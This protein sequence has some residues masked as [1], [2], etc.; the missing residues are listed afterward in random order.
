[1]GIY[2]K[3]E[4]Y[5]IDYYVNGRRRREKVGPSRALA[6][7]ALAV[8]KGEI[9]REKYQ[10]PR[11]KVSMFFE[12][13][14]PIYLEYVKGYKKSYRRDETSIHSLS[15]KFA[16]RRLN[17]IHPFL[18]ESYKLER[19]R[20]VKPATVN[21]E[22]S[23]L[24]HMFNMAI[25]WGYVEKNPM[26]EVKFFRVNNER[27]RYLS[28]EEAQALVDAC[29][30]HLRPIVIV[31]LNTGMRRGEIFNLR[32]EHVDFAHRWIRVVESKNGESRIIP[33]NGVVYGVLR[34]QMKKKRGDLVFPNGNGKKFQSI[35]YSFNRALE[36]AGIRDF[37]FHDLRHTFASNLVMAGED[38]VT[39]KELLGHKSIQ[40]TMRYSHL[41]Q[42]H[43]MK[44]VRKLEAVYN[45]NDGHHLDTGLQ[46]AAE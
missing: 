27:L 4:N 20:S 29:S 3:G 28:P 42:Q 26:R 22:L 8:R 1:M 10:L 31:A 18:I 37:H 25:K 21:K 39:V 6:K 14:V 15:R 9:A 41:S 7:R 44:A 43:K 32:W 45:G 46:R 19:R 30:P 16:G 5:Y 40:M 33:M 13:F 2:K 17:E 36:R 11:K 24:R 38:L 23:C 12:A 34:E 35:Q